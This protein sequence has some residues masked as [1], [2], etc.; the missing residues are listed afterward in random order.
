LSIVGTIAHWNAGP[1][2]GPKWFLFA[3]IVTALPCAW[4]GGKFRARSVSEG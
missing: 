2:Y 3:L 1:E 4:L